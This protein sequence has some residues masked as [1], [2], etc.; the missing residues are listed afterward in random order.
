M[1]KSEKKKKQNKTIK[2]PQM[3]SLCE[4]QVPQEVRTALEASGESLFMWPCS[5]EFKNRLAQRRLALAPA[6]PATLEYSARIREAIQ[7]GRRSAVRLCFTVTCASGWNSWA[8]T[9]TKHNTVPL[10]NTDTMFNLQG[11]KGISDCSKAA[12]YCLLI[13]CKA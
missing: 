7:D 13:V 9:I 6:H 12:C 3:S 4:T 2:S 11:L 1:K 8:T 10:T 5:I